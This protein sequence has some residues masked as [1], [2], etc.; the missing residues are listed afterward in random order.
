[1]CGALGSFLQLP[2]RQCCSAVGLQYPC[3]PSGGA[4][5]R[6]GNTLCMS[7][8]LAHTYIQMAHRNRSAVLGRYSVGGRGSFRGRPPPS[9]QPPHLPNVS[10]VHPKQESNCTSTAVWP[11]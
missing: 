6:P 2:R 10:L 7:Y 8:V 11:E 9:Q 3:R 1:M 4:G 5:A